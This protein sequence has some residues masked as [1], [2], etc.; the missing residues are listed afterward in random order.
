[1]LPYMKPD[2]FSRVLAALTKKVISDDCTLFEV[3]L[4]PIKSSMHVLMILV[5]IKSESP[6]LTLKVSAVEDHLQE[7]TMKFLESVYMPLE[8]KM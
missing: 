3:N 1:M 2:H 5:Q 7:I 8:M 4:N 6:T